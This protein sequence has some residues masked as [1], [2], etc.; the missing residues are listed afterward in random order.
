[1]ISVTCP[2]F[3]FGCDDHWVFVG[4][5][6]LWQNKSHLCTALPSSFLAGKK[7]VPRERKLLESAEAEVAVLNQLLLSMKQIELLWLML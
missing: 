1:M 2:W 3:V 5:S 4:V 7:H 6:S